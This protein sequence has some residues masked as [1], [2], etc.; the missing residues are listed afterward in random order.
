MKKIYGKSMNL[1]T[2]QFELTWLVLQVIGHSFRPIR[3]KHM[4]CQLKI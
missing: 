2:G 3:V 1:M 4:V